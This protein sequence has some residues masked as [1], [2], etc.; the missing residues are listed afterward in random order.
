MKETKFRIIEL[1]THQV[2][3]T[4]DFEAIEPIMRAPPGIT[5]YDSMVVQKIKSDGTCRTR[6]AGRGDQ[7]DRSSYLLE[8]ISSSMIGHGTIMMILTIAAFYGGYFWKHGRSIGL[9]LKLPM[10]LC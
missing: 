9:A 8:D 5:V 3:L 4:K 6:I 7:Q 1:P 10:H 2:L